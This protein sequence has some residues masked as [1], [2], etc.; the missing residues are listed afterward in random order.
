MMPDEH[1]VVD[2]DIED[3]TWKEPD[4]Q[5]DNWLVEEAIFS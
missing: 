4:E 1:P 2:V 3:Y 5:T